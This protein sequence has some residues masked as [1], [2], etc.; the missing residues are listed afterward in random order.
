MP[1]TT[2][3]SFAPLLEQLVQ[4]KELV[5]KTGSRLRKYPVSTPNSLITLRNLCVALAPEKTLEVGLAAGG[6][7]LVLTST[8]RDLGHAPQAQH[9]AIDPHQMRAGGTGYDSVGLEHLRQEGLDGYVRFV[10]LPS[11]VALPNL[12]Q[13]GVRV[14]FAYIDGSHL[15]EDVFVDFYF[16]F[17]MLR[18][19]GV[20]CFDDSAFP[21]V[22]KV[23]RFIRANMKEHMEEVDLAPYRPAQRFDARYTLARLAGRVQL[24]AF[25]RVGATFRPF[26]APLRDF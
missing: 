13:E 23:I 18:D 6:S 2:D 19:D 20:L 24:R 5:G 26:R 16:T 9:I 8:L 10:G 1:N 22:R 17:K 25:R 3:L 21:D 4:K 11:S 12:I 14:D 7:A 15:F